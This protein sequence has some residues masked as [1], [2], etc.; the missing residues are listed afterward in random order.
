[1]LEAGPRQCSDEPFQGAGDGSLLVRILNPQ[2]EGSSMLAREQ[3]IEQCRSQ[4][5][6]MQVACRTGGKSYPYLSVAC[7]HLN[8]PIIV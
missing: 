1:M 8:L 2:D 4:S 3:I 5:P 7:M 6:D